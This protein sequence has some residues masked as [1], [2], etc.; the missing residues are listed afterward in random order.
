MIDEQV[1]LERT[2]ALD[3]VAMSA[4]AARGFVRE[5]LGETGRDEWAEAATLAVTEV[6]TNAVLHAHTPLE[7]TAVVT[8]HQL[9]VEV[10]DHNPALPAQRSYAAEATTGRGLDL[11]AAYTSSFGVRALGTAGKVV[12]FCIR[13]A[14]DDQ[15]DERSVDELLDAWD[16]SGWDESASD[17]RDT[18]AQDAAG[19]P[20][21]VHLMGMPPLLWLAAR[22][23]HD[24]LLR[25]YALY[26]AERT[27]GAPTDLALTDEARAA[28]SAALEDALAL[29]PGGGTAGEPPIEPVPALPEVSELPVRIDLELSVHP[30]QG[31]A[32]RRLQESLDEAEALALDERMLIRPALPEIVAVRDW[33]CQQVVAQLAGTAPAPWFGADDERFTEVTH[34]AAATPLVWDDEA[35]RDADRGV[36]AADDANRIVAVSR[37]LAAALGW[38]V[39][40]LVGR[41]VVTLIPHR[42][43]EA[44]VAGFSRHLRTGVARI[45]DVP[46]QVPVLQKD[47]S[48]VVSGLLI[49]RS[50]ISNGGRAVYIAW[51]DVPPGG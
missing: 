41:R 51:I 24:A 47:G 10:R 40:E 39:E 43:R 15:P 5:L 20:L 44:H 35:V 17:T 14:G 25:E 19:A 7:V 28:I 16:D 11:V 4:R 49:E 46:L 26:R 3:P 38:T 12:W 36:V 2:Y 27:D 18:P 37:P 9:L 48:E 6:V 29:A 42:L 1:L 8:G 45:I 30:S 13:D 33:A 23:H 21:T 22:E 32:F 31:V 34:P 50:A